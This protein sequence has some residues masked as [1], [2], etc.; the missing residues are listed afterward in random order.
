MMINTSCKLGKDSN[1]QFFLEKKTK[2]SKNRETENLR[3][4]R[5]GL[6][7]LY[8]RDQAKLDSEFYAAHANG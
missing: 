2:M 5:F 7:V 1:F 3:S 6:N 4:P 8:H